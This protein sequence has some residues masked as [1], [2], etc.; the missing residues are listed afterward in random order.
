MTDARSSGHHLSLNQI[1]FPLSTST[2]NWLLSEDLHRI[3][4]DAHDAPETRPA[5]DFSC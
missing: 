4:G 3:R 1:I 2:D 5:R